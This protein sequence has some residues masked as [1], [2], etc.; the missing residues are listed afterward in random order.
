MGNLRQTTAEV[1]ALLDKVENGEAGGGLK[2]AEERTAY[3]TLIKLTALGDIPFDITEEERAY[4]IETLNKVVDG[5]S[6]ILNMEGEIFKVQYF[7][8]D[9]STSLLERVELISSC[10]DY[11]NLSNQTISLAL[12]TDGECVVEFHE[13]ETLQTIYPSDAEDGSDLT[14]E[15]IQHNA[16]LFRKIVKEG[17][18]AVIQI[19]GRPCS[20]EVQRDEDGSLYVDVFVPVTFAPTDGLFE[21][22]PDMY[23]P[24]V[25]KAKWTEDGMVVPTI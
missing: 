24:I 22:F 10:Y 23:V 8:Y 6:V 13:T 12:S 21:Q 25:M 17:K 9:G 2:Y 20:M 16:D 15:M 14:P 3:P 18:N 5:G 4:N 1:Q 11:E 19:A 7:T